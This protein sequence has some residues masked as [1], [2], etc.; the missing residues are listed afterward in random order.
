MRRSHVPAL[1]AVVAIV[2]VAILL[3]VD[4]TAGARLGTVL[5]IAAVLWAAWRVDNHSGSCLMLTI[6]VLLVLAI[7]ALLMVGLALPG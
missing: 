7:L 4:R 1:L 3:R 2:A 6:L 5:A